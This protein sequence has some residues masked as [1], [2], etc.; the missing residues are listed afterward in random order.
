[1]TTS[2]GQVFVYTPHILQATVAI[3][4]QQKK[5]QG[6]IFYVALVELNKLFYRYNIIYSISIA[7]TI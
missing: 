7:L 4:Y 2:K 1:M 3:H 6:S 5:S